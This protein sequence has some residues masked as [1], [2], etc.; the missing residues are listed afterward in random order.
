MEDQDSLDGI[1][2]LPIQAQQQ[3]HDLAASLKQHH[4]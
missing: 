2:L 4:R 3:I 1:D